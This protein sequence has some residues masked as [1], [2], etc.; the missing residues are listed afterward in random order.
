MYGG[1]GTCLYRKAGLADKV[2]AVEDT[3]MD[4]L[5][6]KC[7]RH[8]HDHNRCVG[9]AIGDMGRRTQIHEGTRRRFIPKGGEIPFLRLVLDPKTHLIALVRSAHSV[10]CSTPDA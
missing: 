1:V 3:E 6:R 7:F 8:V 10:I 2:Y 5:L 9:E 4:G